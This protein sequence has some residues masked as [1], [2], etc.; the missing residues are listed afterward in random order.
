MRK[1]RNKEQVIGDHFTGVTGC[2]P[3]A[4]EEELKNEQ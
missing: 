4:N 3:A 2:Q 1:H